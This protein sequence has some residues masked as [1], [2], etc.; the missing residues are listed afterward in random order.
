MRDIKSEFLAFWG[1]KIQKDLDEEEKLKMAW[2]RCF[3]S[4]FEMLLWVDARI[5]LPVHVT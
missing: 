5:L 4:K 2:A 1:E 3:E